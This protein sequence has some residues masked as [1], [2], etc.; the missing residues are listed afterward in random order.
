MNNTNNKK[1]E[2]GN[3]SFNNEHMGA[4][5]NKDVRTGPRIVLADT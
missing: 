5:G 3:E 4:G 1:K 2:I